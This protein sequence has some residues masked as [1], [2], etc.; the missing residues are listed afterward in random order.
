MRTVLSTNAQKSKYYCK[1]KYSLVQRIHVIRTVKELREYR[2]SLNAPTESIGFVPTMG[3]LHAGHISLMRSACARNK[4]M[5]ASIFVNPKQFSLG[6]DFDK[7]PRQLELD[8]DILSKQNFGSKFSCL[9]APTE[10]EMYPSRP[11]CHI[12]P[13][14]FSH[15]YEGT[16]RPDFFR[17]VATVVGKLLNIV[18]PTDVYFGQKDISQCILVRRMVSDLNMPVNVNVIETIREESGL[19]MSSRNAYL[20]EKERN[21]AVILFQALSEGKALFSNSKDIPCEVIRLKI[22]AILKKEPLVTQ[23]EYI[24]IANPM[25][26]T[27]LEVC[28]AGAVISAAIRVGNVRLIDNVLVG[29]AESIISCIDL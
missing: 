27:E 8:L 28:K 12:E 6:E 19:A 23:I 26:M 9:F 13:T 20:N 22:E 15:I 7:Y 29:S 17:G 24:S 10:A 2:D 21:A 14:D 4:I 18:R 5:I 25:D 11:L 16:K 1:T 3:A